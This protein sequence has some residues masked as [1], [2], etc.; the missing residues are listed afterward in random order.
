MCYRLPIRNTR[1]LR[2]IGRNDYEDSRLPLKL[3]WNSRMCGC[4]SNISS[5][6]RS[7]LLFFSIAAS[8]FWLSSSVISAFTSPPFFFRSRLI[9][10]FASTLMFT[11]RGLPTSDINS[12]RSFPSKGNQSIRILSFLARSLKCWIIFRAGSYSPSSA[13]INFYFIEATYG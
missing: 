6:E 10:F 8:A 13:V 3:T 11:M 7:Q 9:R 5:V 2:I 12:S 1:G 4:L